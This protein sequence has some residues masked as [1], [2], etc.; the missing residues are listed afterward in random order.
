MIPQSGELIPSWDGD[1]VFTECE[2][3]KYANQRKLFNPITSAI[4]SGLT[5]DLMGAT[6]FVA[7]D[8]V[9]SE[10]TQSQISYRH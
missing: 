9:A 3:K 6:A 2:P 5:G 1:G 8:V 10:M 7:L 4:F